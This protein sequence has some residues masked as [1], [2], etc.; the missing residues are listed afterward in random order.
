MTAEFFADRAQSSS[1]LVLF[2]NAGDP[3]LKELLDLILFLD[4]ARVDCL[5]LAIPF[6]D[7]VTDGPVIRRSAHRALDRGTTATDVL[8]QIRNVRSRLSH[9]K[10]ALLADWH[11]TVKPI[12]LSQFLTDVQECGADALLVHAIPPRLRTELYLTSHDIGQSL[13]TTCYATSNQQVVAEAARHGSAYI[14]LAARYGTTGPGAVDYRQVGKTTRML[15]RLCPTPVAVGFGV[16]NRRQ[17]E[18]LSAVGADAVIVG[19]AFVAAVERAHCAAGG[20]IKAA[21]GLLKALGRS[22]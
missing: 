21:A 12:G 15:H 19:S 20:A 8:A 1:G 10:I 22:L 9:M 7:S 18:M 2:L 5:E 3:P 13:I 16:E 17:I 6:P 11:Y 14:Y 4:A